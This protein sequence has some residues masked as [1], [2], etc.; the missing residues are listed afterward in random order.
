M[1]ALLQSLNGFFSQSDAGALSP[2]LHY[3]VYFT[4]FM[5]P[6]AAVAILLRCAYSM[7]R[8]RYEPEVWAYLDLPDGARVPLRHWE[9]TIGRARSADVTVGSAS[10]GVQLVLDRDEAGNWAAYD[11][12]GGV[13]A[14]INGEA[15]PD[16]G[17][18]LQ[19][20]RPLSAL[21]VGR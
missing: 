10:A 21:L 4:R 9:C 7:F 8:E 19:P 11:V 14:E 16:E 12:G 18:W 15:I 5:L 20:F 2:F 13:R 1:E 17:A 3:L 6:V